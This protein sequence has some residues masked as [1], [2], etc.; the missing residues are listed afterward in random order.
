MN[1]RLHGN[2]VYIEN[3]AH[4]LIVYGTDRS[5]HRP[6][7]CI[8]HFEKPVNLVL[9]LVEHVRN[10]VSALRYSH[11]VAQIVRI[12]F[13]GEQ[14]RIHRLTASYHIAAPDFIHMPA[15]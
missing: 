4:I 7:F 15:A 11:I 14:H 5:V 1:G 8:L 12:K 3:I 2:T 13:I 6:A 10:A 9:Y